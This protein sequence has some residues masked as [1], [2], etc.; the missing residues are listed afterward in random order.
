VLT[1][2]F[3]VYFYPLTHYASESLRFF[4]K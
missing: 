2:V 4:I 3:G 1:V